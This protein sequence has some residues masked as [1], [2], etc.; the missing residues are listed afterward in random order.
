MGKV[1]DA[2]RDVLARLESVSPF[3]QALESGMPKDEVVQGMDQVK[4]NE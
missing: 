4:D 2:Y 1:G 3:H